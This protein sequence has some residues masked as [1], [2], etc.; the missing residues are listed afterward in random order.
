MGDV[1]GLKSTYKDSIND[2]P[3][4]KLYDK[5]YAYCTYK[6]SIN[7]YY[8]LNKEDGAEFSDENSVVREWFENRDGWFLTL[9]KTGKNNGILAVSSLETVIYYENKK[10][11]NRKKE[12]QQENEFR[13]N[14]EK[15]YNIPELQTL[16]APWYMNFAL[17]GEIG[18]LYNIAIGIIRGLQKENGGVGFYNTFL[19]C[20]SMSDDKLS[21]DFDEN[22]VKRV[23]K[24]LYD[25]GKKL[26]LAY[27]E[28]KKD[29]KDK[30]ED[31]GA[32]KDEQVLKKICDSGK[33]LI[34]AYSEN[35]KKKE[36]IKFNTRK[37]W[38][39][40]NLV[41]KINNIKTDKMFP[42]IVKRDS[43]KKE[44]LDLAMYKSGDFSS[45]NMII[46]MKSNDLDK[47]G[48]FNVSLNLDWVMR[49]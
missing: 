32:D 22:K 41:K 14:G 20:F 17:E 39:I 2:T 3:D 10:R 21:Y 7:G 5:I 11:H 18:N 24:K 1:M 6:G 29:K 44:K 48:E 9:I 46:I 12:I 36:A 33:K 28:D 13:I 45:N 38:N 30:K 31:D 34:S 8:Y 19:Q 25:S 23:L 16:D 26:I 15:P 4:D 37:A 40:E 35:E 47:Y 49:A 43:D 42:H 27:S